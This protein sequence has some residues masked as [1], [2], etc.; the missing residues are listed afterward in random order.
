MVPIGFVLLILMASGPLLAWRKTT[1]K[2]LKEQF[3]FPLVLASV[4]TAAIVLIWPR[5]TER[6]SFLI[7]QLRLPVSLLGF[8]LV[9]FVMG[10]I[11]QEFARGARVRATQTGGSLVPSL[12]GIIA[13]KRRKYGGYIVHAG[14]AL[15]FLGWA[16]R[17]FST[18]KD[19]TLTHTGETTKVGDLTFRY[20]DFTV[21][22]S[23]NHTA[24]TATITVLRGKDVV[25]T[26]YPGRNQYKKGEGET[27]T[28]VAIS[29]RIDKD[30]YLVLNGF[31]PQTKVANFRIF[32]NPLVNWVWLGFAVL[33][34]GTVIA[35][36]KESWLQGFRPRR[37][38][39]DDAQA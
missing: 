13:Q 14:V 9:G 16:G 18:E 31:D 26:M 10:T 23:P 15:M 4:V 34:F 6:S 25:T 2:K 38:E 22:D 28:E 24:F 32:L 19:V 39:S 8:W 11:S 33:A 36:L 27:T 35:L 20:D 29:R 37:R 1:Q 3:L 30:I 5:S 7:D 21:T 12:I 17:T